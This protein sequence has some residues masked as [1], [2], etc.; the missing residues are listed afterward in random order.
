[1]F[2]KTII[3]EFF[4]T[5]NFS[6]FLNTL[7]LLTLK[8]PSLRF[9]NDI[10]LF[11]NE[12]LAFLWAKQSKIVSFYNWRSAIYHCLKIIGVKK[13]NEV[14][15]SGY[16]CVSV[17]NSVIQSWAQ[18]IYS[19]INKETLWLDLK[20]L[21]KNI[22]VNTKVIIVQHTFWKPSQ[23]KEILKVVKDKN[24]LIIEDCAHSLWSEIENK[25]L[26]TFWD[27]AIFSTWRDKVISS[28][29]WWFLVINNK[30]YFSKSR[31]IKKKLITPNRLL[32][33]RNL[34]YNI[35]WYKAYKTYDF[36]SLWKVI[37]YLSRKLNL[38]TE[39][40]TKD[41]KKCKYKDFFYSFP[42]SLAIIARKELKKVDKYNSNRQNIAVYY[43]NNFNKIQKIF[44]KS[45]K[46]TNIYFRYPII[47]KKIEEKNRFI[48]YMKNNKVLVW[49]TWSG[50]NIVPKWSNLEKAQYTPWTC[51]T[52]ENMSSK[53]ITLPNHN[54]IKIKDVKK[55]VKL[56]NKF[57][58]NK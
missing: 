30:K 50:I 3:S 32:V 27:F 56:I 34:L 42:N 11:E 48:K 5:V 31:N 20:A 38:I 4:T 43:D 18:I 47:F 10:S 57:N 58:F 23:I 37:I 13:I 22:N 40:L 26:W 54:L 12:L 25:K 14:I 15:V 45:K 7:T 52:A 35:V 19:D 39:I 24:I 36:L 28:V 6:I 1:M 51:K 17:S 8:L 33:I 53:I 2:K 29:T 49:N 16:T 21:K 9:W 41:E 44:K 55:I 46:E